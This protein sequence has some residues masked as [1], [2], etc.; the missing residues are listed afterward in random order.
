MYRLEGTSPEWERRPFKPQTVL[1]RQAGQSDAFAR[2]ESAGDFVAALWAQAQ[3]SYPE[4]EVHK[5]QVIDEATVRGLDCPSAEAVDEAIAKTLAEYSR[6]GCRHRWA[7]IPLAISIKTTIAAFGTQKRPVRSALAFIASK[8]ARRPRSKDGS[9]SQTG[10]PRGLS[11]CHH[12]CN[13]E[14]THLVEAPGNRACLTQIAMPTRVYRQRPCWRAWL[15]FAKPGGS[16]WLSL[17][18]HCLNLY[19]ASSA[20]ETFG[21]RRTPSPWGGNPPEGSPETATTNVRKCQLGKT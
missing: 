3:N 13:L 17:N 20:S 4:F 6:Q 9:H 15:S 21:W 18:P 14:P 7:P 2:R 12:L 1:C 8:N 5:N 11:T 16:S 10:V 19:A